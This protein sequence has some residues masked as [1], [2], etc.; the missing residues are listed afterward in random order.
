MIDVDNASVIESVS[1]GS[2]DLTNVDLTDDGIIDQSDS[3]SVLREADGVAWIG[4][5]YFASANKGGKM[6][7]AQY[8]RMIFF[9]FY[10]LHSATSLSRIFLNASI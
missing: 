1:Q 7:I 10:K 3:I 4:T 8:N 5:E 9:R 6:M 2:V